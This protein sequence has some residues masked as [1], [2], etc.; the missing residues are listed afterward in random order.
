MVV[1]ELLELLVDGPA[2]DVDPPAE[3]MSFKGLNCKD[4]QILELI[5][6]SLLLLSIASLIARSSANL[7]DSPS[8]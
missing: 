6:C 4:Y 1:F 3:K 7:A 5:P 2:P 8:A